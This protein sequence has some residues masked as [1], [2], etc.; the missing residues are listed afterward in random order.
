MKMECN[1][2]AVAVTGTELRVHIVDR[3]VRLSLLNHFQFS[4]LSKNHEFR[5]P[6]LQDSEKLLGRFEHLVPKRSFAISVDLVVDGKG[7]LDHTA[8][9]F[10]SCTRGNACERSDVAG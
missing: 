8:V 1:F 2:M 4:R 7:H 6:L 9:R 10:V 3:A 5:V